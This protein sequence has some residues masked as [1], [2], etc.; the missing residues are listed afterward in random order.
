VSLQ[1]TTAKPA[2]KNVAPGRF[3]R[4][5]DTSG[6]I[7]GK[8]AIAVLYAL[9]VAGP[10]VLIAALLFLAERTRRRRSDHRL[11]EETG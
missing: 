7:L 3:D 4:F 2:A 10:F 9:V 6:D 1:L 5:L 8:E 11:L